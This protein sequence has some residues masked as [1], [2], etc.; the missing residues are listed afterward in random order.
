M[1][2]HPDRRRQEE[3]YALWKAQQRTH[4]RAK[5]P[6]PDQQMQALFDMLKKER[7]LPNCDNTLRRVKRWLKEQKLPFE[8]VEAWLHENGGYCDCEVLLNAEP[9]W[10]EARSGGSR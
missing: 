5:P 6:L 10:Q 2:D 3:A 4:G 9:A 7:A 1:E 8:P